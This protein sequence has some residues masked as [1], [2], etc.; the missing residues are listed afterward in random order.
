[1]YAHRDD[2]VAAYLAAADIALSDVAAAI[3]NGRV[4]ERLEGKPS[5]V[6]FKRLT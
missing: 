1:M 4:E 5:A 3:K 2:H 6:G